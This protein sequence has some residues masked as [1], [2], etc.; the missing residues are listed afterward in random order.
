MMPLIYVLRFSGRA[1]PDGSSG[2]ILSAASTASSARIIS[3]VGSSGLD[4]RIEAIAGGDA[5]FQSEVIFTGETSFQESGSILFGEGH[6][7][8]FATLGS[9]FLGPGHD[10]S[11]RHGA[12][13]WRVTGGEGQ[14]AGLS[15][16]ITSNFTV[17]PDLAITDHHFGVL[18]L[19]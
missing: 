7:L 13:I 10:P 6:R 19:P 18:W 8:T 16:L 15:G 1:E 2:N 14:F 9:G 12:V 3:L 17:G 11:R 5:M 4:G